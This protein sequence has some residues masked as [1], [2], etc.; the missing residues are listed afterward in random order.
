MKLW[1]CAAFVVVSLFGAERAR[2]NAQS[3]D[4]TTV[5][6]Q[7]HDESGS[8]VPGV[9]VQLTASEPGVSRTTVSDAQGRYTFDRIP[10][11]E[12]QLRAVLA[13][14]RSDVARLTI[15]GGGLRTVDLVLRISAL[16]ETVTVTRADETHAV[17]PQAIVILT[18]EDVQ[19]FQRRV[20]PA[21]AFAGV[22]GLFVENRR[23]ASLS[24][25]VQLAIR[26]P[27]PRFGLR[28]IHIV[29]DGIPLTLADGTTEP[30][31]LDLGSVGQVE[32]VR[33]P[34]SVLYGNAAGGVISVQTQFPDAAQLVLEPDVQLGSYGH[35]Q[36]QLKLHGTTGRVSYLLNGSQMETDG[37]RA[38]SAA[39]VRRLNLVLRGTPSARTHL[40][41]IYN[42]YDLPFGES[43]NTLDL[44]DARTR[45]RSTRPQAF[46]Q[47]WGESTTQA[48]AGASVRH[49][50][51]RDHVVN[52]TAWGLRRDVF[53]PIPFAIVELRRSASGFRSDYGGA[54][55]LRT[56][57]VRWTIGLDVSR[58][59]DDRLE[60]TNAGVGTA[61]G[62]ALPGNVTIDQ[63][64]EVTSIG[65]FIQGRAAVGNRWN[66]SAGVRYDHH[67]FVA[68]DH[69]TADGDQSGTRTLRAVSPML[70]VTYAATDALN[71]FASYATAYQ[72]PTTVELSNTA[73]GTGGFNPEL[74]P[75]HLRTLEAG[76]RGAV[77][78]WRLTFMLSGYTSTLDDAMVQFTRGDE[79][80]FFRNAGQAARRGIEGQVT[81]APVRRLTARLSYTHQDF[82]FTRFVS[83][84]GDYSG[85][86][87]PGVPGRQ[88]FAGLTYHAPSG[89]Y[90]AMEVRSVAS[91]PVNSTN[92]ISN[93]AYE[94]VNAR[95]GL[96]ARWK[97][98]RLRPF[99]GVD[100]LLDER[101]NPSVVI[102]AQG[103][104]FF[105]PAPGREWY[106]GL[107]LRAKLF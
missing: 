97:N 81:W 5:S 17:V 75:E 58:Q 71:I 49:H 62:R 61:G 34:S 36:Q 90:S 80:T 95:V 29:Q 33:G 28:G 60:S 48:Q 74:G 52:A 51:G 21:E 85:R 83:P 32:I 92:S 101:Y 39:A 15:A 91:Y 6:G 100:N 12:Y 94:V 93:W 68:T 106:A 107:T 31:G 20:S 50:F 67:R 99:V 98:L 87:E 104:R 78:A 82:E 13:G 4:G 7:I 11:G 22:P 47:G 38:H 10:P 96:T 70:G 23:N 27:L 79:A 55:R 76:V 54:S 37:F 103:N 44:T 42:L 41:A 72:T 25:G 66:V 19:A 3:V 63:L 1:C 56:L 89:L 8:V 24:G 40:S 84:E 9:V 26:S 73:T 18:G 65:P 88:A 2:A 16:S 35:N 105:E 43:A 64:E 30:T 53:N 77:E 102:N 59:R 46:T 86:R 57:P 14:F 45:P 69:Q